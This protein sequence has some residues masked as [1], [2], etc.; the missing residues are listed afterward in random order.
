MTDTNESTTWNIDASHSTI[1]FSA[2]HMMITT[3]KGR[4]GN[5]TGT[6]TVNEAQPELSSTAVVLDLASLDTRSED[7]DKHLQSA[8]FLDVEKFPTI[9]F[10]SREISGA[11]AA[12]GS[13]FT[14]TG[15]LTIRD[16]TR[17][18]VL[19]VTYEGRGRDPW[20]G[21]RV[22]FSASTKI[23]RR[24][25]GLTWNQTLETGGLLVSN[26]IRISMDLQAVRAG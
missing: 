3:V 8:D 15:D 22:S 4:I 16:V 5:V 13:S 25:F 19:D 7:R 26:D 24:D 14:V 18:V 21:E 11:N 10:R 20:G 1:E 6:I 12:E 9:T 2:R 23:D 17:E